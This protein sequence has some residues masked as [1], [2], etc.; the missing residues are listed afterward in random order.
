MPL[1]RLLKRA[2]RTLYALKTE[3]T[4]R[5]WKAFVRYLGPGTA[6]SMLSGKAIDI[7]TGYRT[8]F[9]N[10]QMVRFCTSQFK[11][12]A[13]DCLQQGETSTA[14]D[15]HAPIPVFCLWW[16]GLEEAPEC[17]QRCVESHKTWLQA[18]DFEYHF[19]TKDNLSRYIT[20]PDIIRKRYEAG[21][22]TLT[23]LSDY[24]RTQLLYRY[25]GLWIDATLLITG[26][27]DEAF[28]SLPFYSNKKFTYSVKNRRYI[29]SGRWTVYFIKSEKGSLLFHFLSRSY[30]AY[31]SSYDE[32]L[33][34]YLLDYLIHTACLL[35]PSVSAMI[36]AVPENNPR[37][38]DLYEM[39]NSP[40]VPDQ[41][42]SLL[43]ENVIHKFSYKDVYRLADHTDAPT[44]WQYILSE[45]K[46]L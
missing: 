46:P 13:E 33:D 22:M 34:Y 11:D 32:I 2:K 6:A 5:K 16:S 15:P 10:K 4:F 18:P 12:I 41:V 44:V 28:Y 3:V 1:I 7:L 9:Y 38:F 20:L 43:R 35:L 36:H 23:H 39:R 27:F 19:L 37:T 21:Q 40:Y 30:E 17:V 14:S 25:G 45:S 42:S 31:W 26:P 24:I 8:S 29:P